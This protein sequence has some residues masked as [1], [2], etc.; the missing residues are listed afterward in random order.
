MHNVPKSPLSEIAPFDALYGLRLLDASPELVRGSVSARDELRQPTGVLHGGVYAA[1]AE[2]LA[3][4]GTN[5]AVSPAG[6][7]AL[8]MSNSTSFLRPIAEGLLHGV[9]RCRHRG[10]LT[11]VWDV[12]MTDDDGKLCAVSRVTIAIRE[13]RR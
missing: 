7:V 11:A 6:Q 4:L 13:Q 3:S 10:R 8:G 12:E 5:M 2:G 1:M 9:A